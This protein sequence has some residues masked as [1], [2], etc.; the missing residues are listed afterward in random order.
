[1]FLRHQ[2][3][4]M[5]RLWGLAL[6]LCDAGLRICFDEWVIQPG[7][8][9]HLRIERGLGVSRTLIFCD[10]PLAFGSDRVRLGRSSPLLRTS[11]N[12]GRRIIPL[13]LE[14]CQLPDTLRRNEYP[15]FRRIKEIRRVVFDRQELNSSGIRQ[16]RDRYLNPRKFK[17]D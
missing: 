6:R 10:S 2:M 3:K 16:A 4:D 7:D 8:D 1:M 11:S 13:L 12:R 14:D 15:T 9:I 5:F 17:D